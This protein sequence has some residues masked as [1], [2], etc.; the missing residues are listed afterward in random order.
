LA[1]SCDSGL[2]GTIDL[3]TKQVTKMRTLHTNICGAV[4]FVP[5]RPSEILSA[6][7]DSV[8]LHF[9]II[10]GSVLSRFDIAG[11]P[12]SSGVSLSPPFVHSVAFS[13][14]GAII[15]STAAGRVWVGRGGDK[16]IASK[17]KRSRK[18]EGLREDAGSWVSVAEG[19]VVSVDFAGSETFVT[20]TL[21]GSLSQY[22]IG[23]RSTGTEVVWS[24]NVKELEKVNCVRSNGM[25]I[26]VG[27]F[28][29]G[30][31]GLVEVYEA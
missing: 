29:S 20:C 22:S 26:V 16:S 13:E 8:L 15:A 6:G 10:Q 28:S 7:Y 24:R 5:N 25:Y 2:V 23:V 30:S 1:F 4:R 12:P 11:L 31:K 18:W 17:K 19:P 21:L 9:D 3:S 27:G 14:N